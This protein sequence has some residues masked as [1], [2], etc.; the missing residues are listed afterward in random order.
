[1]D[2]SLMDQ[3]CF[4]S[5]LILYVKMCTFYIAHS[6]IVVNEFYMPLFVYARHYHKKFCTVCFLRRNFVITLAQTVLRNTGL[7]KRVDTHGLQ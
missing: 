1:M 5:I 6:T 2:L 7:W 4:N 3:A